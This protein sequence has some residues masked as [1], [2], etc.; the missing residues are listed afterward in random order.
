M[1]FFTYDRTIGLIILVVTVVLTLFVLALLDREASSKV[2]V[3]CMEPIEREKVR[4]IM[5]VAIDKGLEE[6]ITALFSTWMK[7]PADQPRRAAVG[8]N[9]AINAHVR[10]TADIRK[11]DPPIC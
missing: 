5:R 7:D 8:T 11:W 10:A 3:G 4:E 6:Q 2:E 9:N 1:S